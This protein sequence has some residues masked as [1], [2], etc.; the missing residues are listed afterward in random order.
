MYEVG[1]KLILCE[2]GE[3]IPNYAGSWVPDLEN[4]VG[5]T[6][7]V[8]EVLG[9]RSNLRGQWGANGYRCRLENGYARDTYILD[10]RS[11]RFKADLLDQITDH[12]MSF[13]DFLSV[14]E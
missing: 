10:E 13:S 1:D 2:S 11:L 5:K 7:V 8:T 3:D 4:W 9:T 14:Y 12:E 6:V